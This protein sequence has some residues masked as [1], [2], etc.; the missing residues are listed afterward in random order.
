MSPAR[1]RS[2]ILGATETRDLLAGMGSPRRR[3]GSP[4]PE[5]R[6]PL[7]QRPWALRSDQE[8]DIN[9]A[10]AACPAPAARPCSPL[11]SPRSGCPAGSEVDNSR[12]TAKGPGRQNHNPGER[13][14]LDFSREEAIFLDSIHDNAAFHDPMLAT[15]PAERLEASGGDSAD[16]VAEASISLFCDNP[17]FRPITRSPAS[18]AKATEA[19]TE[20][21]SLPG[22]A[23]EDRGYGAGERARPAP[24]PTGEGGLVQARLDLRFREAAEEQLGQSME[25]DHGSHSPPSLMEPP[26]CSATDTH[27]SRLLPAVETA[28]QLPVPIS[29][30]PPASSSTADYYPRFHSHLQLHGSLSL[31]ESTLLVSAS[32]LSSS[33]DESAVFHGRQRSRVLRRIMG[34][35]GKGEEES[36]VGQEQPGV[37]VRDPMDDSSTV[38]AA[39]PGVC[40]QPGRH[41]AQASVKEGEVPVARGW[42]ESLPGAQGRTDR[43]AAASEP[44]PEPWLV[45]M[46]EDGALRRVAEFAGV[47]YG[48]REG[49]LATSEAPQS[50]TEGSGAALHRCQPLWLQPTSLRAAGAAHQV[51]GLIEKAEEEQRT[52][53]CGTAVSDA[54]E[55]SAKISC[56]PYSHQ[57][58][59]G[60]PRGGP[61]TR[62]GPAD[63]PWPSASRAAAIQAAARC[64]WATESTIVVPSDSESD[65]DDLSDRGRRALFPSDAAAVNSSQANGRKPSLPSRGERANAVAASPAFDEVSKSKD[66]FEAWQRVTA[67]RGRRHAMLLR[68]FSEERTRRRL[69]STLLAWAGEVSIATQEKAEDQRHLLLALSY[70]QERVLRRGLWRWRG[71]LVAQRLAVE[72]TV[73]AAR[74]AMETKAVRR[75]LEAWRSLPLLVAAENV[76]KVRLMEM[77]VHSLSIA[78]ADGVARMREAEAAAVVY[79]RSIVA[80]A[81]F[82]QWSAYCAGTAIARRGR[83]ARLEALLTRKR[84]RALSIA[85]ASWQQAACHCHMRRRV[86]Q[87]GRH[88]PP[89]PPIHTLTQGHMPA[90]SLPLSHQ[91]QLCFPVL[92]CRFLFPRHL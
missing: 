57:Q 27:T 25:S 64:F 80:R 69:L 26:E 36:T 52:A 18:Y 12:R 21:G 74:T 41:A 83:V 62:G 30:C 75:A 46:R 19:G 55:D 68:G 33:D 77:A 4:V 91:P 81:A 90:P 50:C 39:L 48:S 29:R 86:A 3:Y 44:G 5:R 31:S 9:T 14:S 60:S 38:E 88:R 15:V 71:V 53:S 11:R 58:A 42:A 37:A 78:A 34:S 61:E 28:T 76:R 45:A 59:V 79:R 8:T 72:R 17:I 23:G 84:C 24:T 73:V 32:M 63:P 1:K 56:P 51:L 35:G 85:F 67:A 6:Q 70:H 20:G 47:D 49:V 2:A 82:Q 10:N 89:P 7:E 92:S 43:E 13:N 16:S 65:L 54:Q 87:V 40:L 66:S 22:S